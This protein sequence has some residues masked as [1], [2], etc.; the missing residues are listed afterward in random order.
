[1]KITFLEAEVPLTKTFS[2]K[3]GQLVKTG[4]PQIIEVTS[5]TEEFETIEEL[6][7]LLVQ[8]AE[9][10]HS[11]LKGVVMRPLI[12]ESRAG[13]T[14]PNAPTRILLL[15]LDGVKDVKDVEHFLKIL[16]LGNVDYIAQYSCSMGVIPDRGLSAHV[17]VIL[18]HEKSPAILKQWLMHQNHSVSQLR[19]NIGL[20]RT[21]NAL[22]WTLDVSTCQNDKLI[23]IAPPILGEGVVDSFKG[24]RIELVKKSKR[25]VDLPGSVPSAEAN[26]IVSERVL[27]DLRDKAGLP[28]RKRVSFKNQGTI[29]YQANPDQASITGIKTERGFTYLNLNGGDSWGYYH[30][31]N[32]PTFIFNFKGEPVFKTSELLPEYWRDVREKINEIRPD[33]QGTFYLAVRD[34][35]TSAYWNGTWTP[36]IQKLD[37]AQARSKDQLKDFLKQHGQPVGDFVPD[38]DISFQP[39]A[40]FVVD[41]ERRIVNTFIPS[42]YMREA[43]EMEG[44]RR[45][46]V[47]PAIK[48]L[49][50]HAVGD[51]EECFDHMMNW[52]AVVFQF[53]TRTETCWILQG[54]EGTGK[55]LFLNRV[56]RP[57]FKYVVSKRMNELDSQFNG[58]MERCLILWI[59]EMQLSA[60]KSRADAIESDL[61]NYIVE[62]KLSIRRMHTMPYEA[63][64]YCNLII[65]GNK[66]DVMHISP[67]DR[68]FNVCPYQETKFITSDEEL[69]QVERELPAF[70]D[71]LASYPAS[72]QRARTALHNEA[73]SRMTHIT[74]TGLEEVCKELRVGNL[75]FFW[76]QRPGPAVTQTNT[77][78]DIQAGSYL[79][80]MARAARGELSV[81]SREELQCLLGYTLGQVPN[82]PHKFTSLLKHHKLFIKSLK[83]DDKSVRGVTVDWKITNELKQDIL[84]T[85]DGI[86]A[87][88]KTA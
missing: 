54:I 45:T 35:K 3:D 9:A 66:D 42:N 20:T 2:I 70:A 84:G 44:P 88:A 24:P 47:P 12:R 28:K 23:Y 59:D 29:E 34:F 32:N 19:N 1:M 33:Q 75:Q 51:D 62:P 8:H 85:S 76:D 83:R 82:S 60:F 25:A 72:K 74:A 67:T 53:K 87:N 64:N 79:N 14:D 26:K 39:N 68:R 69:D 10:G 49:I 86:Q 22:R 61:K 37:L 30:P 56:L 57:L 11:M 18:S 63:E 7:A 48:R 46:V 52:L 40:N 81:V 17:L 71:Y 58:Y 13:S 6:H 55:G 4:H 38:W 73:K 31:E 15:D 78:Q 27:N 65:P 21:N 43:M 77:S 80:L 41:L 36:A 50:M 16:G 5:H